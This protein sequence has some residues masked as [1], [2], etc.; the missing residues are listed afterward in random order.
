M[1]G[2]H[3]AGDFVQWYV[4]ENAPDHPLI[5]PLF[6]ELHGLPPIL[7]HVGDHEILLDDSTRF[8]ERARSYGVDTTVVVW[9]E[10]FHVFHLFTPL[11]PEARKANR[12][13]VD[14]I[15]RHQGED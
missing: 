13:V 5:S 10:M 8:A 3:E 11:L 14:F 1:L 12:E 7:L 4:G 9:P 15:R 6:A 2:G